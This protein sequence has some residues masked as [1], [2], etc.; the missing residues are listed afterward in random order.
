MP[1]K[2]DGSWQP[3]KQRVQ[4]I[5]P[6]PRVKKKEEEP[7]VV[8]EALYKVTVWTGDVPGAGTDANVSVAVAYIP[9]DSNNDFISI[10]L[11]H[12]KRAQLR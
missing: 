3:K 11:F 5:A 6:P 10:V 1:L 9:D 7:L 8:H 4:Y 12:V 2:K